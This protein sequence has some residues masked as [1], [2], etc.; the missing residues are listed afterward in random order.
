MC[1][2]KDGGTIMVYILDDWINDKRNETEIRELITESL[3]CFKLND[4]SKKV[5]D[6]LRELGELKILEELNKGTFT[7]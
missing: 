6:R 5:E 1:N 4:E 2:A 7:I 3:S